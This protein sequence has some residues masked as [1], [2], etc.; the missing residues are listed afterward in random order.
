MKTTCLILSALLALGGANAVASDTMISTIDYAT[1]SGATIQGQVLGTGITV[2][3]SPVNL[4]SISFYVHINNNSNT[5]LTAYLF[6]TISSTPICASGSINTSTYAQYSD[7]FLTFGN[8]TGTTALAADTDYFVAISGNNTF[9]Q[10]YLTMPYAATSS[11]GWTT[12]GN[13]YAHSADTWALFGS[14][15]VLQF[16]ISATPVPEPASYAAILGIGAFGALGV[17]RIRRPR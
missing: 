6:D 16:S 5:L 17:R 7:Q 15:A 13:F 14:G 12:D 8:L 10:V 3:N 1:F 2:G 4:D 9:S 11:Y